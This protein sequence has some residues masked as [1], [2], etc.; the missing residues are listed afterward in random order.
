MDIREYLARAVGFWNARDPGPRPDDRWHWTVLPYAFANPLMGVGGGAAL[1]GALR[2]GPPASP[3][4]SFEASAFLT[5]HGQRGVVLRSQLRLPG[6]DWVLDGDLGTGRFPNPAWGLGGRSPEAARTEV[7]RRQLRLHETAL[8]RVA[9]DLFVG[10][11]YRLDHFWDL[12]DQRAAA[13]EATRFSAYGIGTAGRSSSSGATLHLRWDSRDDPIEPRGGAL[14]ELRAQVDARWLGSDQDWGSATL[15]ARGYLPGPGR[16]VLALWAFA[17]SSWGRTPYLLLPS[18][19]ADPGHRS[20]RGSVEGRY[21]AP[22]LLYAEAEW[23]VHL[24]QF[25][26]GVLAVNAAL[27]SERGSGAPGALFQRAHPAVAAGLRVLLDAAS[28]SALALDAAWAPGH[29]PVFYVT[30]E[31][32]F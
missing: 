11:G 18:L 17:W 5:E 2:L 12:V 16:S 3:F 6:N 4:S 21:T 24:W 10:L 30:A 9:G 23:R 13:G 26:G 20:G 8:R 19:G 22:E 14:V 29:G 25:L 1:V 27:P 7:G 28:R 15:D 31:Q 32:T